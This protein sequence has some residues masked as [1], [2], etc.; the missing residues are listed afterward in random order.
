MLNKAISSHPIYYG[1]SKLA[2]HTGF[3]NET[4][5]AH[6]NNGLAKL[7]NQFRNITNPRNTT[8]VAPGM[9]VHPLYVYL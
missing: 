7:S 9:I 5:G 6:S 1:L 2:N 3:M 4:F 8:D